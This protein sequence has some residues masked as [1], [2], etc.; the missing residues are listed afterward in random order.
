MED[1]DRSDLMVFIDLGFILLV[2]FLVLT[3]TTPKEN[4][5]LPARQNEEQ[6]FEEERQVY[7]VLFDVNLSIRVVDMRAQAEI[8]APEGLDAVVACLTSLV[9]QS[10]STVFVLAPQGHATVQQLVSFLDL[11][12]HNGWRCTVNN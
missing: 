5:P 11:C 10:A 12:Y 9:E 1:S 8:C 7:E 6:R 2:G 4:V 3:D